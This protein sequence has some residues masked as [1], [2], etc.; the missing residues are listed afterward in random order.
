MTEPIRWTYAF[1]D[2][3]LKESG[4][5]H[6]FW[7]AVTGTRL[8][9]PRGDR[10]EFVTLLHDGADA[11]VKMQGVEDGDGGAHL[12]LAVE[13]VTGLVRSAR[14]LGAEVVAGHEGWA[15]LRSPGGQS[16][17]VVPWQGESTRP[18][19]VEVPGG[20]ATSRLDQVCL[21]L[22]PSVYDAEV[23]FWGELTGWASR[24]GAFPEFHVVRPPATLP[25]RILLQRRDDERPASAHHDI[26]C[27]DVDAV[28]AHHESLGAALVARGAHWNVMRDPAG[29]TYCLTPRDPVTGSL[30]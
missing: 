21:D 7:T 20:G 4:T 26:A 2:R 22:A 14:R 11:C 27:S 18:P 19:V 1:V 6:D 25:F 29:G 13:D 15:V 28:R 24:P 5:A 12:D 23:A 17:C 8:S 3:P 30:S 10:D 9:A 16:F